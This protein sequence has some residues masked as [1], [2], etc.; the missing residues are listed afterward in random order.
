ML[1]EGQ[2]VLYK[3]KPALVKSAGEKSDIRLP[4]GAMLKVRE[5]DVLVLHNGPLASFDAESAVMEAGQGDFATARQMMDGIPAVPAEVADLVFGNSSAVAL[6]AVIANALS[7]SGCFALEEGLLRPLSDGEIAERDKK[8]NE[9]E[10][11][12]KARN[13][14]LERALE[15]MKK[16][17]YLPGEQDARFL[18]EIEARASGSAS[19]SKILKGLKLEDTPEAAHSFL[20]KTGVKPKEWDP[21]PLRSGVSLKAP[22]IVIA[23]PETAGRTDLTGMESYAIDNAWSK[24]PDDAIAFSQG[25]LWVHVADPAASIAAGSP[26]DAEARSRAA[27]LYLPEGIVPMLPEEA[28]DYFGLGLQELSPALSFRIKLDGECGIADVTAM[29][30]MVRV[31]RFSYQSADGILDRPGLKEIRALAEMNRAKR[32]KNGAVEI[33]LP[34]IHLWVEAGEPK[35]ETPPESASSGIVREC[36]LIAGEAAGRFAFREGIPFPYYGQEAP[37]EAKELPG[38]AGEWAK[39]RG[40]R[41]GMISGT[42]VAHRGLGLSLYTQVT[43]PLRRYQDLLAHEQLSAYLS[44]SKLMDQDDIVERTGEAQAAAGASRQAERSAYQHWKLVWLMNRPEWTGRA[45]VAAEM[46]KR[47]VILI[48]E[49]AYETQIPAEQGLSI[50]QEFTVK[51]TGVD[52]ARLEARFARA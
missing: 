36:M 49:L 33:E 1:K 10:G 17:N 30:S 4:D 37:N 38:L 8:K 48:P 11:A 45:V 25:E 51:C 50:N 14:F 29:R 34:E 6:W 28:L 35:V 20:L 27:T 22:N 19:S 44:C 41:P 16:G 13:D 7:G 24:D 2:L 26:V 42:P 21:Y 46:G 43:S 15:G 9:R 52:L 18:Q 47:V 32:A 31:K 40:M 23:A 3:N 12:E 5:K 39:R